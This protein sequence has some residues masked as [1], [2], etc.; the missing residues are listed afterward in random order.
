MPDT[1]HST[2]I[3]GAGLAGLYAALTL[4][5]RPVTILS[6]EPLGDG[7][8]S[9]WAQGG[10]AAAMDK[11][12]TPEAHAEDTVNAGDGIVDPDIASFVTGAAKAHVLELA[13][14]GTPFDRTADGGFVMSKEAAHGFARVVRVKGDQAGAAIMKTL[15][16]EVK[17][18]PSITV[19]EGATALDLISKNSQM[20]GVLVSVNNQEPFVIQAKTYLLAAGGAGSLFIKTTNPPSVRGLAL[21]MAARAG[22]K[23]ADAEFVQFHPTAIDLNL[24]PAPLATEALRGEGA[25]LI[26]KSGA[27][28]MQAIHKDAELAPRDIVARAIFNEHQAGNRPMLDTRAAIGAHII[29]EFPSVSDACLKGGI[30]PVNDPI[31]VVPAAHYHMGGVAT[32]ITGMSTI[33]GLWVAGEASS[34]GLHGAN[35]LASNGLLEALVYAATCAGGIAQSIDKTGGQ[36]MVENL[37]IPQLAY[38]VVDPVAVQR[39]RETMSAKVGVLREQAGLKDALI[40]L[41]ALDAEYGGTSTNFDNML[42]AATLIAAA[43]YLRRESRGGHYR[44]DYPDK[45]PA[46]QSR[47]EITLAEAIALRDSL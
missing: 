9:A 21:G 28:F 35:R 45:D 2:L 37:A 6:P 11:D 4:A 1:Q 16:A 5:P 47:S 20:Q 43:A 46:F 23:I 17:R 13:D 15:V 8:S 27:R 41:R 24:D 10:V 14:V 34:T 39:L 31:P 36:P 44:T 18:T 33:N 30:D 42:A 22:A 3:I 7:A 40:T 12:D 26:N 32:D 19:I 29:D 25:T 38:A